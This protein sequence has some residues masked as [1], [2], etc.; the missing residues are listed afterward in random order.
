MDYMVYHSFVNYLCNI[1]KK[2]V[3]LVNLGSPDSTETKDVRRYLK[4]FLTD[5]KV[6]DVWYVRNI[7]LPL[8]ILPSRPQKSA[9]AY[10]KIWWDE[11]SPLIVLTERLREK[12]QKKFDFPVEMAMRYGNPSIKSG[13][14]KLKSQGCEDIF[15]IPLYPQYA[16][17]TTETVIDKTNEV[18]DKYFTD[19]KLTYLPAFYNDPEYIKILAQSIKDHLPEEFDK[20]LFSY[21]GIP[22]RHIYK[23]DKTNTCEIGK[24]CFKEDNPSHA[25]CY[26]HQS[27]KVT[28]LVR[29]ELGL[30]NKQVFQSFQSR[31]GSDPWIQPYTDATLEGFPEKGVKKIAVVAPA[32]ISDCLETLEELE[33]EG[34][35]EFLEAGGEEFTYIPCLND[36]D[37][38]VEF[39]EHKVNDWMA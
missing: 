28:E 8:F 10:R 14:E 23:T 17:S 27:Y 34:K 2:G 11:G 3:L 15:V 26:R 39:L 37:D 20:V 24:C 21:H 1:M 4:E 12:L 32:F 19:L 16:M 13:L 29:K 35:E 22:E 25:T 33:M 30:T 36:R 18:K 9:E 6:I 7:I 38:L 5:P 31:L